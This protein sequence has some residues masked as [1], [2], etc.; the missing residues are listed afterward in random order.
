MA[1]LGSSR[2]LH[3]PGN[4]DAGNVDDDDDV[5]AANK[6]LRTLVT[7]FPQILPEV[8]REMLTKFDGDSCLFVIVDQLVKNKDKWVRGRWKV[9]TCEKTSTLE[10]DGDQLALV[11]IADCFRLDSYKRAVRL[12]L[13]QEF[14][15][16]SK[17]TVDAVMAENNYSYTRSRP[18]L[19]RIAAKN[20][21]RNISKIFATWRRSG[22]NVPEPHSLVRWTKSGEAGNAKLPE[23]KLTGHIEL[24]HE[25]YQTVMIPLIEGLKAEQISEDQVLAIEVNEREAKSAQALQECECC[26]SDTTFE[27]MATCT[28]GG[29]IICFHCLR[30]A[31]SEAIFGQSWSRN[32]DHQSGHIKCLA[33]LSMD[34]CGGCIPRE[35]AYRAI[36]QSKGGVE[37]IYRLESRLADEELLESQMPLIRCPF[38]PYAEVDDLYI[39]PERCQYR[40][41]RSAPLTLSLLLFLALIL[42]PIAVIYTVARV[43][44][45]RDPPRPSD[46]ISNSL[47]HLSRLRYLPRRFECKSPRCALPSCMSC[48]KLWHDPHVCHESAVLSLRTTIE[49]AR[50]AAVK[51]TCPHCGLGF[52][53][54]SGCN[55]LSCVCGYMMCYIC[56]QGLGNG[57]GGEGYRHFCQHFRPAGGKCG[58]CD[59][60]DLYKAED[61]EALVKRAGESAEREWRKREGMVGVEGIGGVEKNAAELRWWKRVCTA[62]GLSD[63]WIENV[64]IC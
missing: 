12:A 7:F 1:G 24:D 44:S 20:W 64:L 26:F 5:A 51:R 8:F 36:S 41:N 16:L 6:A 43:F 2:K 46:L 52:V 21:R 50:T 13:Y 49:A 33:A 30:Q 28:T 17:S 48:F 3:R 35:V 57:V 4:V 19:Q 60:C 39:P 10:S 23:L 37:Q 15:A 38:C 45:F 27:Q 40:L 18:T 31:V 56:R 29:H 22:G 58:D 54:E 9:P 55:K 61:E 32:I 42:L 63:W 59:R 11:P 47:T 25:L 53:K 34:I 14:K 62:Q